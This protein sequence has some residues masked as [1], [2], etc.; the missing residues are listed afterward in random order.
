MGILHELHRAGHTIILVT[1]AEELAEQAE[2]QIRLR[3]GRIV[4]DSGAVPTIRESGDRSA[5]PKGGAPRA[6][7]TLRTA[8]RAL[9]A[10]ILRTAL[11]L[12][13]IVIGIASVIIMLAIGNGEKE[14][15]LQRLSHLGPDLLTITAG[16]RNVRSADG[17]TA[18]LIDADRAAITALPNVRAA[19]SEYSTTVTL[20]GAGNDLRTSAQATTPDLPQVRN[21]ALARGSFFG[22]AEIA[23]YAAVAVLGQTVAR[24]LFGD[25]DPLGRYVLVNTVPFQVIGLLEPRGANSWGRDQ[26]DVLFVPLSTAS[27]RL[28]GQRH[29]Q[30]ITVQVADTR[31]VD[32]TQEA[33]TALLA[34]R[35]GAI[36]FQVRNTAQILATV[37]A[38]RD[39][40]TAMLGAIALV[41]LLVG[42][43]GVMNIML[44]S[45]T[46][47]T[48][49]IGLRMAVGARRRDVLRQFSLEALMICIAG[50]LVGAAIGLAGTA[51]LEAL[52]WPI[53]V[54][55]I[56]VVLALASACLT[57]LAAG[58]LPARKA[59]G[60]D[61]VRALANE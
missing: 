15:M 8:T 42:G 40:A 60:L 33:V 17:V 28:H 9:G 18:T 22:E 30:S 41:S 10:N 13:G 11:T 61:P 3:D 44:V 59:A 51:V 24:N 35:H 46:E 36:D 21:W 25:D 38:S 52:A 27:L 2:R 50:G 19:I 32:A 6:L 45:V 58:Y 37:T 49:E 31:Q 53:V 23:R 12:L 55:P 26:D 57:G 34:E 5:L 4:S 7:D 47:R 43:I 39:G 16:A 14:A 54:E 29:V 56:T 48:R 1:H 20:R